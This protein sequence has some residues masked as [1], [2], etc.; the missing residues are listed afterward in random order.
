MNILVLFGSTSDATIYEPLCAYL[1]EEGFVVDFA[2]ISAHRNPT[3]LGEK[4]E[5]GGFDAV[6]AGA[7]L[8]AHLPGV[9]ASKVRKP[10]FGIPV[11]SQFQ[12]LDSVMSIQM[13]PKGIPVLCCGTTTYTL[14]APFLK[15]AQQHHWKQCLHVVA[16]EET[17]QSNAYHKE[18][19][20]LQQ[21]AQQRGISLVETSHTPQGPAIVLVREESDIPS[22][23]L[24]IAVP[25]IDPDIRSLP[26]TA[27]SC[28]AWTQT[29]GLWVGVNNSTNA[30]IFF[31][32]V[33]G[34]LS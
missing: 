22:A 23:P 3:Q 2:V 18:F 26:H 16:T 13:M 14:F 31:S 15:A 21:E 33:F 20:R 32:L 30:L 7:G 27:L 11:D 9:V 28:F 6:I 24:C 8:S 29:G 19:S 10:V 1:R 17:R 5:A 25:L 12:G 34:A 4:L